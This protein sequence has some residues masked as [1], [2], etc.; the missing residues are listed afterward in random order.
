MKNPFRV[1]GITGNI[2]TG[3]SVVRRMLANSGGLG[4]DADVLAHRMLYPN[5]PAYQ[6]VIEAFGE[7]ILSSD[8]QISRPKLGDIVFNDEEKLALLESLIHP[9]VTQSIQARLKR[10]TCPFAAVEAIKLIEAGI[11]S[12][13]DSLWVSHIPPDRQLTRLIETRGMTEDDA[14]IRIESQ[15]PQSIK[16][17]L[18]DVIIHTDGT[19]HSTWQQ[20]QD[21]LNDTITLSGQP[22]TLHLNKT[23]GWAGHTLQG[24]ATDALETFWQDH[25]GE[26]LS[27]LYQRL[28]FQMAF[29][30]LQDEELKALA[31]WENWNF[32]GAI[33]EII[34]IDPVDEN[35]Q[36]I[37]ES[38]EQ[39]ARCQQSEILLLSEAERQE[40]HLQPETSGYELIAADQLT[41]PAWQQ[42]ANRVTGH[43]EEQLWVKVLS[44]PIETQHDFGSIETQSN[45]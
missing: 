33:K 13:C 44:Q 36:M 31:F 28:G 30:I 7:S 12:I 35:S 8:G 20:V 45:D 14:R 4:I 24:V 38:F 37:L 42:A 39:H 43:Q 32:S 25:A 22:E 5:G 1:I 41:Y 19:F 27:R 17:N 34:P 2:A 10:N 16:L 3:K 18:A 6:A 21:A 15:P 40:L 11:S 9:A 23:R 29:V 26:D